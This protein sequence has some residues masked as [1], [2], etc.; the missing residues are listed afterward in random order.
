[1]RSLD[2]LLKACGD[3]SHLIVE[4]PTF[5]NS[6][7]GRIAVREGSIIK[8]SMV[9]GYIIA[10]LPLNSEDI[11]LYTPAQWKGMVSKDVTRKKFYREFKDAAALDKWGDI[12]K[13]DHDTV[14]AVMMLHFWLVQRLLKGQ[15]IPRSV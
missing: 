15:G 11:T 2:P 7:A 8:L 1:M 13:Y 9:L 10:R 5:F 6:E 4:Q 14:D 12:S 3:V